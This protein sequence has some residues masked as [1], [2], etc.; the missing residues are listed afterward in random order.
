LFFGVSHATNPKGWGPELSNFG[1]SLLFMHTPFVTE[2]YTKFEVVINTCEGGAC[3]LGH[4]LYAS[5]PK[6]AE[7]QGSPI[8]GVLL[9]YM[10]T[11][12]NP[13]RPNSAC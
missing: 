3:I 11:P 9:Y 13:E 6:T 5:H 8:L 10:P 2:L 7:F 1:G 4:K 12:F